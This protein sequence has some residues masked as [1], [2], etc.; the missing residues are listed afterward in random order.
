[1]D[2]NEIIDKLKTICDFCGDIPGIAILFGSY[3]RNEA[4]DRSD[5]DLY[6]E[7]KEICRHTEE[8]GIREMSGKVRFG[9]RFKKM[10]S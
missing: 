3:S 7:P 6:I 4:T 8:N 5:I 2:R 9:N 1:M 10:G